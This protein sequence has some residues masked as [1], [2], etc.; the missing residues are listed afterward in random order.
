MEKVNI[1]IIDEDNNI[2]E[3]LSSPFVNIEREKLY[4]YSAEGWVERFLRG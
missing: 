1:F 3:F 2:E 4:P